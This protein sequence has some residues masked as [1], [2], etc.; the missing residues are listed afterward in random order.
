M[1]GKFVQ[2]SGRNWGYGRINMLIGQKHKESTF[3][4][5]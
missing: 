3:K 2:D 1:K 5:Q 4:D